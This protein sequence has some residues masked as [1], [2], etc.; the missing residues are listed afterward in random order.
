MREGTGGGK[1]GGNREGSRAETG[2]A[3]RHRRM[4]KDKR[5]SREVLVVM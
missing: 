5:V 1:M 3:E 4:G 2:R